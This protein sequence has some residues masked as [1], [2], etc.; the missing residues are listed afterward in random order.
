[1]PKKWINTKGQQS[2]HLNIQKTELSVKVKVLQF[3]QDTACCEIAKK[4]NCFSN[5]TCQFLADGADLLAWNIQR[6]RD[7]GVQRKLIGYRDKGYVQE[8]L[9]YDHYHADTH[10]TFVHFWHTK[11]TWEVVV[12]NSI[13]THSL[14]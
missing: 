13:F 14:V 9:L 1:M 2:C 5:H 7:F 4:I 3:T 10:T 6:G 12:I 8:A 11:Q